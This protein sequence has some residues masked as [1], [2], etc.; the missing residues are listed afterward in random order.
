MK[1]SISSTTIKSVVLVAGMAAFVAP[2][3][4]SPV[5]TFSPLSFTSSTNTTGVVTNVSVIPP[6]ANSSTSTP[7][8]TTSTAS[9]VETIQATAT[10]PVYADTY[11]DVTTTTS[12]VITN[13]SNDSRDYILQEVGGS[14]ESGQWLTMSG[15]VTNN[16]LLSADL[17]IMLSADGN[18][19]NV[20]TP[21]G[22]T[23]PAPPSLFFNLGAGFTSVSTVTTTTPGTPNIYNVSA[24]NAVTLSV[25]AGVSQAFSTSVYTSGNISLAQFWLNI[26][27]TNYDLT[28][29]PNSSSVTTHT[30]LSHIPTLTA[31][32]PLPAGVWL[33]MT[34]LMG[35]LYTGK[36]KAQRA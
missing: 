20:T 5:L 19:Q 11:S 21:F 25:A 31:A 30:L 22:I 24:K 34:G 2:A 14:Y 3:H 23:A 9:H 1:K 15:T 6:V 27:G 12:S 13:Y 17:N 28:T 35:V 4:A 36:K 16:S 18:Y 26:D 8:I 7:V 32:V 10:T 33:F 29:T